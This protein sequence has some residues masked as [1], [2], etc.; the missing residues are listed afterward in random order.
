[1]E[2]GA[3]IGALLAMILVVAAKVGTSRLVGQMK[4]RIASVEQ[5][6]RRILGELKAAQAQSEVA[7]RNKASLL[8]KKKKLDARR[9]QLTSELQDIQEEQ[10]AREKKKQAVRGK[11]VRSA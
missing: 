1:M 9:S 3:M 5:D 2:A 6:K 8:K 4:H 7:E 10:T 11:L